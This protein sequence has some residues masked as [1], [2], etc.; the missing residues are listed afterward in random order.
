MQVVLPQLFSTKSIANS[1]LK[2]ADAIYKTVYEY[3]KTPDAIYEIIYGYLKNP[4]AIYKI[5]Y[6]YRK[7]PDG[8]HKTVYDYLKIPDAIRNSVYRYLK[9]PGAC[10]IN[11]KDSLKKLWRTVNLVKSFRLNR[12]NQNK[13]PFYNNSKPFIMISSE[14]LFGNLF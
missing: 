14:K 10:Y 6:G 3:L 11:G 7:N 13:T 2:I 4:D 8:I 5:V 1:Y 9:I 12:Y